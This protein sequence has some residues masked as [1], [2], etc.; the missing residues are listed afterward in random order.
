VGGQG[1]IRKQLLLLLL[2]L[3]VQDNYSLVARQ[4]HFLFRILC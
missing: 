4:N 2:L 1:P 3:L